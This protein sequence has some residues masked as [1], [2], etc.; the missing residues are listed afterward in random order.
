M[1]HLN[2]NANAGYVKTLDDGTIAFISGGFGCHR[3]DIDFRT[4]TVEYSG[5]GWAYLGSDG[6]S[7]GNFAYKS[8]TCKWNRAKASANVNVY[9]RYLAA[10]LRPPIVM[11]DGSTLDLSDCDGVWSADG[12]G[13][14]AN[15]DNNNAG[16]VSFASGA[17]ITVDLSGRTDLQTIAKSANPYIVTWSSQPSATFTL[18]AV[19]YEKGYRITP[20]ST[21]LKVSYHQGL[22][23]IVK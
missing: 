15:R 9:G 8:P 4:A 13:T 1:T 14:Y 5:T 21:G 18:D 20:D 16:L 23:I 6:L 7:V 12:D 17:A 11:E 2:Y 3:P 19:S 22:T 10:T